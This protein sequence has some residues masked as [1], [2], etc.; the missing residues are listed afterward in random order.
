MSDITICEFLLKALASL[1]GM[2]IVFVPLCVYIYVKIPQWI[3]EG[4][5]DD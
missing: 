2:L 1:V 5:H 4:F 3:N